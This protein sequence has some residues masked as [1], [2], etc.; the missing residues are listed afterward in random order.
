V[1]DASPLALSS[2]SP[3]L[4]NCCVVS[5]IDGFGSYLSWLGIYE[6]VL[7]FRFIGEANG[8]PR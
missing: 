4:S 7:L 3:T 2:R 6:A 1:T 5:R 8:K